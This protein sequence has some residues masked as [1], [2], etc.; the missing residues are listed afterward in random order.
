MGEVK[1]RIRSGTVGMGEVKVRVR[2][3]G[4]G[5]LYKDNIVS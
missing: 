4:S 3:V 5:N 1:I 2:G